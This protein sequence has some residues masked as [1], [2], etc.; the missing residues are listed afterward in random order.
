MIGMLECWDRVHLL[1]AAG[2]ATFCT[3][4]IPGVWV[5]FGVWHTHLS[6][7]SSPPTRAEGRTQ[8]GGEELHSQG[9]EQQ[10]EQEHI[11]QREHTQA[12][13][14]RGRVGTLA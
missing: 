13:L 14:L 9:E 2:Y 10:Q 6:H 7:P 12:G 11:Q 1:P 8:P 3:P 5:A 4:L